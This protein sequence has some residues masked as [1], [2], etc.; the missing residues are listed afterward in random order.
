MGERDYCAVYG[1]D[2]NRERRDRLVCQYGAFYIAIMTKLN[3]LDHRKPDGITEIK[4][5]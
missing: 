2:N 5:Q 4:N 1:C 3:M